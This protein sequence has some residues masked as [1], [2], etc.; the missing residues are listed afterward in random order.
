M[1]PPYTT[2]AGRRLMFTMCPKAV[3]RLAAA[4]FIACSFSVGQDLAEVSG[5]IL[6]SVTK[7][8]VPAAKVVLFRRTPGGL[9]SDAKI[10]GAEMKAADPA[11]EVLAIPSGP[12]G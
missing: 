5:R 1:P 3:L 2:E 11:A 4:L 12:E 10:S 9:L 7:Q 8:G 6:D